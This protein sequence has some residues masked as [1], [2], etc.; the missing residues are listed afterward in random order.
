M[1]KIYS[2]TDA[3]TVRGLMKR[4]PRIVTVRSYD[5][6]WVA[7]KYSWP[8]PGK[9]REWNLQE[10]GTLKFHTISYDR[11]RPHGAGPNWT[12]LSAAGGRLASY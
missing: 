5:S 10:D 9:A 3:R 7:N 12:A 8:A 11:K 1:K 2:I 4:D 6:G